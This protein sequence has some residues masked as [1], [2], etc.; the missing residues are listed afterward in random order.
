METKG[1]LKGTARLIGAFKKLT[2]AVKLHQEIDR[3]NIIGEGKS[4]ILWPPLES[5]A[6]KRLLEGLFHEYMDEQ[7][8]QWKTGC[9]EWR[10]AM[11]KTFKAGFDAKQEK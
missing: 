3:T 7:Y 5:R 1:Q 10:E 11:F 2:A 8:P 6:G 9:I 4:R